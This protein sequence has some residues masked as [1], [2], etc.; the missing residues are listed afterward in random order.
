M[1][2]TNNRQI[3][4]GLVYFLESGFD[5]VQVLRKWPSGVEVDVTDAAAVVVI[6]VV[7]VVVAVVVLLGITLDV[8][9][10]LD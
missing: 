1:L 5:L 6:D 4:S 10:K 7:F 3:F 9:F 8:V 2:E